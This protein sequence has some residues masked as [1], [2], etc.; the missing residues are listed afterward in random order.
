M[1]PNA[2]VR[3]YRPRQ[4]VL[5]KAG[6]TKVMPRNASRRITLLS[7]AHCKC[8]GAIGVAVLIIGL[9]VTQF[10]HGRMVALQAKADEI[11]ASNTSIANENI[12][13]L[14]ARAQVASKTQV[15]A[16]AKTKLKLFEPDQ[17]QVRRM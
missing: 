8:L 13:L 1:T 6:L 12:R 16:L 17:G 4:V 3:V 2:S 10:V 9:G 14:A 7:A 11:Q 15:A 5:T